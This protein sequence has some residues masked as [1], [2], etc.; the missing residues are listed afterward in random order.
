LHYQ[1]LCSFS[2]G[3]DSERLYLLLKEVFLLLD[4]GDRRLFNEHQLSE[5]RFYALLHLGQ[6]PGISARELSDLMFCDKSN[7]TRLIQGML[8]D[9][10]VERRPHET[11][12]RA[13]RLYLT[14][15]GETIRRAALAAHRQFNTARLNDC[16]DDIAQGSLFER[17][18]LLRNGLYNQLHTDGEKD[19]PAA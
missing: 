7:V 19:P 4:D 17:L 10:L 13:W 8:T 1:L 14:P 6:C 9:R 12:G 2:M 11:D 15:K 5:A 16:L 3:T 18:L